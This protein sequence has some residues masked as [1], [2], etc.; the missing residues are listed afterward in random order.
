MG[1]ILPRPLRSLGLIQVEQECCFRRCGRL[2][3][4]NIKADA[5]SPERVRPHTHPAQAFCARL[6][7]EET[8]GTEVAAGHRELRHQRLASGEMQL[9]EEAKPFPHPPNC[10]LPGT[11]D[12]LHPAGTRLWLGK[13]L[14]SLV[15]KPEEVGEGR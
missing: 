4:I 1:W 5:G 14:A 13:T 11:G 15:Y 7:G 3:K 6:T 10:P 2:Y 8:L 9:V 12:F